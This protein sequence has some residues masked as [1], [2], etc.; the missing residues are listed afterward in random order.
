MIEVKAGFKQTEV[1]VIPDGYKM[2]KMG[3]Q[4]VDLDM[5]EAHICVF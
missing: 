5:L 3:A 1:G 2:I 4:T